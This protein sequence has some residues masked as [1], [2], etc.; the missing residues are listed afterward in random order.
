VRAYQLQLELWEDPKQVLCS[1]DLTQHISIHTMTCVV[2]PTTTSVSPRITV[3]DG[4]LLPCMAKF[5]SIKTGH[6]WT[7]SAKVGEARGPS[8][9]VSWQR[10]G[11][12]NS[13]RF[14]RGSL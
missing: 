1:I 14:R 11:E 12:D 3:A 6:H 2:F 5:I 4:D 10:L 13:E 9:E 8:E 7:M